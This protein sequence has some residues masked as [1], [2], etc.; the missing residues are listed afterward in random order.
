[1][2]RL[3]T[4]KVNREKGRYV[5]EVK[6][7]VPIGGERTRF[8]ARGRALRLKRAVRQAFA[9]LDLFA[10]VSPATDER[11][12][13]PIAH[14]NAAKALRLEIAAGDETERH[15]ALRDRATGRTVF[16]NS[17]TPIQFASPHDPT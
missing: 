6:G 2:T 11:Y 3:F 10:P 12:E 7:T 13:R 5:V 1:M 17:A 16:V 9:S 14:T 15:Y 4:V 8:I